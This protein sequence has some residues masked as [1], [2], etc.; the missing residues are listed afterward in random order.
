MGRFRP[1]FSCGACKLLLGKPSSDFQ[2]LWHVA[3]NLESMAI[4]IAVDSDI[5]QCMCMI[6][7]FAPYRRRRCF[8]L[9][10]RRVARIA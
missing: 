1:S 9:D 6:L 7:E 4:I 2:I 10:G 5:R 8:I 3:S